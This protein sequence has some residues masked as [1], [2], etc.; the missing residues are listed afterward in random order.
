[1]VNIF[2]TGSNGL[3]GS[4]FKNV[5][6]NNE[7]Y[8][9]NTMSYRDFSK[10][11]D[12]NLKKKLDSMDWIIHCAAMTNVELCE[13]KSD[14]CYRANCD[15]TQRLMSC[16]NKASRF[17]FMSSTG[18]YGN[19]KKEPY[20]E[21]DKVKPT[22]VHHKSKILA[23]NLILSNPKNI[24]VRTGWLYGDITKNDFVSKVVNQIEST[25]KAIHSNIQ[26][27]G[28]PTYSYDLVKACMALI[29]TEANGIFNIVAQ[30][31]AS[32]FDYVE[33]IVNTLGYHTDIIPV[34]SDYFERIACVSDNETAV[35][36]RASDYDINLPDWKISLASFLKKVS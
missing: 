1:M 9:L 14:S 20:H 5:I 13:V 10:I 30:G 23:E 4:A 18:V 17:L 26:Q 27:F 19:Y 8:R 36:K 25:K 15:L 2:L 35:S 29:E 31:R 6:K 33:F 11:N 24:V 3:L 28:C 16:S 7:T 21:Y 12:S 32:R 34:N 22:T